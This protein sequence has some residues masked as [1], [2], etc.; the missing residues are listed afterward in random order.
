MQTEL[1]RAPYI[2]EVSC[3]YLHDHA[4]FKS[5]PT[6]MYARMLRDMARDDIFYT[7]PQ[8]DQFATHRI[9]P[10]FLR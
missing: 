2:S 10:S 8:F 6:M 7:C 4:W 5:L 1:G 9:E 3:R